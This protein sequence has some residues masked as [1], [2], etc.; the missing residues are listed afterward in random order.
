V[1]RQEV[2]CIRQIFERLLDESGFLSAGG[3]VFGPILRKDY[4][5]MNLSESKSVDARLPSFLREIGNSDAK[6]FDNKATAGQ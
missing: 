1:G 6:R 3:I 4:D 2:P 5:A